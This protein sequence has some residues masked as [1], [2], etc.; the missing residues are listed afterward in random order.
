MPKKKFQAIK[1]D[2]GNYK[3]VRHDGKE[4]KFRNDDT[5]II[6]DEG[7]AREMDSIHGRKGTQKISIVPYT[8]NE[9]NEKGH[10]Y[11]FGSSAKF[12]RAW[13][14]FEKRRKKKNANK[15]S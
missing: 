10:K 7:V 8:D 13:E 1:A 4:F 6:E 2:T 12:S 15:N 9:T 5:F 11:T 3:G 14:E